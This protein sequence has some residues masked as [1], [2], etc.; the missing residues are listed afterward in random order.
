M[1]T[2]REPRPGARELLS[3]TGRGPVSLDRLVHRVARRSGRTR[4]LKYG[5]VESGRKSKTR[6]FGKRAQTEKVARTK[7][8]EVLQ[9]YKNLRPTSRDPRELRPVSSARRPQADA[10]R[11]WRDRPSCSCWRVAAPPVPAAVDDMAPTSD[12]HM[13]MCMCMCMCMHMLHM[14]MCMHMHMWDPDGC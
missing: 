11:V 1:F 5:I 8:N 2:E 12:M 6:A 3:S 14:C 9:R 13:H 10:A 7:R 4:G